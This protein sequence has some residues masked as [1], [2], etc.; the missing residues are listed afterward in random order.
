MLDNC[1]IS[2]GM[3]QTER[4]HCSRNYVALISLATRRPSLCIKSTA[5]SPSAPIVA[6]AIDT[7][8]YVADRLVYLRLVFAWLHLQQCQD[9]TRPR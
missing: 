3:T 1:L 7:N 4:R 5:S 6:T 9:Q 2:Q 8:M